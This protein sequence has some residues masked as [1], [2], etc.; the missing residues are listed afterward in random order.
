MISRTMAI[1]LVALSLIVFGCNKSTTSSDTL[2][3]T[4]MTSA[5]ATALM[6]QLGGMDG[7][8]KLADA[9]GANLSANPKLSSTLNPTTIN[10]A[11]QGLANEVAKVSGATPPYPGVSLLNALSGKGLDKD[12]VKAVEDALSSAA[13]AMNLGSQTKAS[14]KAIMEPISKSLIGG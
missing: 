11:K 10:D 1:G 8:N 13:D 4:S 12:G 2:P 6:T 9:F 5:D 14:L 3:N 7:V